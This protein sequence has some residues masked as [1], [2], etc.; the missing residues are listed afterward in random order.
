MLPGPFLKE[1]L[2]KMQGVCVC[3][4]VVVIFS[5]LKEK[6]LPWISR[7]LWGAL[8]LEASTQVLHQAPHPNTPPWRAEPT[9]CRP[10][11]L[12]TEQA[13]Q[14][15]V[16]VHKDSVC[17]SML[18]KKRIL[19][20][21]AVSMNCFSHSQAQ[22]GPESFCSVVGQPAG[23]SLLQVVSTPDGRLPES[24]V[25]LAKVRR[26]GSRAAGAP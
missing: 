13:R 9:F 16:S 11:L 17:Q 10:D 4:A 15:L 22:G 14:G 21:S 7:L 12:R 3:V 25:L 6:T 24:P 20:I 5:S 1:R 26:A 8:E 2:E 23:F 19:K 18:R